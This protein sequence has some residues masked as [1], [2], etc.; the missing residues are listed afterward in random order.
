MENEAEHGLVEDPEPDTWDD[1]STRDDVGAGVV[2]NEPT[3]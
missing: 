2:D 3:Q 1:E